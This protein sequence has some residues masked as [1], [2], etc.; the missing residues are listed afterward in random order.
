MFSVEFIVFQ[1]ETLIVGIQ[2]NF[3]VILSQAVFD[4][5]G[6]D[7]IIYRRLAVCYFSVI[8]RK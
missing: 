4:Q 7:S 5:M 3:S 8:L 1:K 2:E 6:A